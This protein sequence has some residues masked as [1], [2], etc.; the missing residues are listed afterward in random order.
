MASPYAFVTLLTSDYYLPGALTL[1]AALRD[2]HPSPAPPPEVDFQTVCLVT[3]ETVDV[4]SI[5][6]LRKAFDVVVGVEIIEENNERGLQLLGRPDLTTV[7]TKLH[8]FRLTQYSKIIFLDAD[9]L[10]IR[11]LSHLFTL[12]HDF[13]AVPDVG[14]PDIFNSGFMVL[15][16]GEDKF[17]ELMTLSKTKGSWDGADQGL[18]NEWRGSN[19]NRLS[20][21]YNTTPT[22]VYTYAPAYERFGSQI[23]AIHFIGAS[24]PW[25]SI[26]WRAPGSVTAQ[27][28]A[29][30]PLQVYDYGSLVDRWYA[31]YDK[32]YRS[33]PVIPQAAY[34]STRYAAAWDQSLEEL[35]QI[36]IEG[37]SGLSGVT[38]TSV[39]TAGEGN[40]TS[41]PLE[42]RLD[43]MRP[44]PKSEN[45]HESNANME[46]QQAPDEGGRGH[47]STLEDNAGSSTP[48]ARPH[49]LYSGDL[50]GSPSV[51][52][53]HEQ[54]GPLMPNFGSESSTA[55]TP[56]SSLT[57]QPGPH[58]T[59]HRQIQP[60]PTSLFP[61]DQTRSYHT[62]GHP[63]QEVRAQFSA[64]PPTQSHGG[65]GQSYLPSAQVQGV[66]PGRSEPYGSSSHQSVQLP[67]EPI[68]PVS[69]PLM[70][71]NPAVEPP[72][73]TAPVSSFPV[74]TYYPN[75][76]DQSLQYLSDSS[77]SRD[78][79]STLFAVPP[80]S[81]IPERLVQEKH[82]VNVLGDD[83]K[84]ETPSPDR[85]K[86]KPVFPWEDKP[87]LTPGRV[88]PST[89]SPPPGQFLL[90]AVETGSP[91]PSP[92]LRF[93]PTQL[94]ASSPPPSGFPPS[95]SYSNAWDT[96]P[97]IQ[98][99]ASRLVRPPQNVPPLAPAF[100]FGESRRRDSALFRNWRESEESSVDGDD[101]DTG[102]EGG[103]APP[104]KQRSRSG[105]L[106]SAPY[107]GGKSRKKEYRSQGVQTI[108]KE[109]K[110]QSVQVTV[111]TDA[112]DANRSLKDLERRQDEVA[113]L[114]PLGS[115]AGLRSP[116][117]TSPR[118]SSTNLA[119]ST[120][121]PTLYKP[122]QDPSSPSSAPPTSPADSR[123]IHR[124]GGRVWD[125][126]RGVEIFKKGSEEV[127]SR[128]LKMGSWEGGEANGLSYL[129]TLHRS[130]QIMS[131]SFHYFTL[132]PLI[133]FKIDLS[134]HPY[135][136]KQIRTVYVYAHVDTLIP[137]FP[138]SFIIPSRLPRDAMCLYVL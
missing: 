60:G 14:W 93:S 102:D 30:Q 4:A 25:S 40:Y 94:Y 38:R 124:A 111:L 127:L 75:V 32:H 72:P 26:P 99:Y 125:P 47:Q 23:S 119:E 15:S 43:L 113:K 136:A 121:R 3:P 12:P 28:V 29:S 73:S 66:L 1:A 69:P 71:W 20:F 92:P 42:G 68:R 84:G 16:P 135:L 53:Q 91:S 19:W 77:S 74:S 109:T 107:P 82:Y 56:V 83:K 55:M 132:S 137:L 126:A 21:T 11:T 106:A 88:F 129:Y 95:F 17:N 58:H 63:T 105:S 2:T 5:K 22:A 130:L 114:S 78:I 117:Y 31:V 67:Q 8:V 133:S 123:P 64:Q 65:I 112:T 52:E 76:W 81:R 118:G 87:R 96:V 89:D 54:Y 110:D 46:D 70:T 115:P 27:S 50:P 100:D 9:I 7:L 6:L 80:P 41:L 18:L 128:F 97:S 98:K 37:F 13:S 35:R 90:P 45:G 79:S 86:I 36:A 131:L 39:A 103:A 101:E 10:P 48:K 57:W 134:L 116:R 122:V 62:G 120:P 34:A 85:G 104:S 108:P 49:L 51:S 59:A 44:R 61:P 24:K 33:Q 138:N